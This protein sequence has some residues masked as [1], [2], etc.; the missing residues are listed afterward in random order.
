MA[1]PA[2]ASPSREN[3]HISWAASTPGSGSTFWFRLRLEKAPATDS[4]EQQPTGTPLEERLKSLHAGKR[5]LLAEDDPINQEIAADMMQWVGLEVD[6]AADG[7]EAIRLSGLHDYALLLMDMQMPRID[8]IQATQAIRAM[9][10]R[11][12]VPIIAMTANAFEDDRRRCMAAGM[13]DFLSKPFAPEQFY[14]L[15]LRWLPR[16]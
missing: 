11:A 13:N 3:W 10:D 4:H 14:A 2:W 12:H 9:K 1:V 6:V 5:V 8:G 7:A 15:L 16:D